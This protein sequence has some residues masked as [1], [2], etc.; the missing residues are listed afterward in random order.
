[1]RAVVGLS[2]LLLAV[3]A[4]ADVAVKESS[5]LVAGAGGV[6]WTISDGPNIG[7]KVQDR[8]LYA[9]DHDGR[10]L[11]TARLPVRNNDWEDL[12]SFTLE[13]KRW[14]I[15]ADVGDNR[16]RREESQLYV[17][18]EPTEEVA[19]IKRRI[20]FRFPDRPHDCEAVTVDEAQQRVLL[21]TKRDAVPGLYAVSLRTTAT[22]ETAT[23]LGTLWPIPK[24]EGFALLVHPLLARYAHQPTGMDIA[25]DGKAAVVLT[26]ANAYL[27]RR[28]LD[29][30]WEAVLQRAPTRVLPLPGMRQYE[31]VAFAAD[32]A[33]IYVS[34][35]GRDGLV[36]LKLD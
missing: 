19:K 1:M 15:I 26:Y 28:Q 4:S 36:H 16:E 18:E 14:L 8:N 7:D 3:A 31:G 20:R 12:T 33:S 23:F 5:G 10:V 35:E 29:E 6:I 11:R 9:L 27:W 24:T 13:G 25:P 2:A 32:G 34:E 30:P 17:V 21:L 22:V